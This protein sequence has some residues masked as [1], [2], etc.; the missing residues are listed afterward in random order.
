LGGGIRLKAEP[1]LSAKE[2]R[3]QIHILKILSPT[4]RKNIIIACLSADWRGKKVAK[5]CNVA[6]AAVMGG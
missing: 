3:Q 2:G 4:Q 1:E 6:E 5:A